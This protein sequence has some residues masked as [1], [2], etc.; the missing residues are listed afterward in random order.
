[1]KLA[2]IA[3]DEMQ[4]AVEWAKTYASDLLMS[5]SDFLQNVD[6][7]IVF[8]DEY[9]T[10]DISPSDNWV[11]PPFDIKIRSLS[12]NMDHK[13]DIQKMNFD[14]IKQCDNIQLQNKKG[15]D[16]IGDLKAFIDKFNHVHLFSCN[17][18]TPST[19]I[20]NV[21][22]AMDASMGVDVMFTDLQNISIHKP[23]RLDVFTIRSTGAHIMETFTDLFD[24]QDYLVNHG[25]E[26]VV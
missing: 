6:G 18:Y 10:M 23:G 21:V 26:S 17:A 4:D 11:N 3:H 24:L 14:F 20:T 25:L 15:I 22:A 1:M 7:R 16:N 8:E 9:Y 5:R 13:F 2:E 12:I 19:M